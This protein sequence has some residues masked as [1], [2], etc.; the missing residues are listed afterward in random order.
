M[1]LANCAGLA[2]GTNLR[3]ALAEMCYFQDESG[4]LREII[5]A[6]AEE[7]A[8][9]IRFWP[10][11]GVY[12]DGRV[13]LYYLGIE[14]VDGY[15][16][17]NFRNLG[18]GLAVMNLETGECQRIRQSGEWRLW[19]LEAD[20]F[21]FG[22]QVIREGDDLLVFGSVRRDFQTQAILGRVAIDQIDEPEAYEYLQEDPDRWGPNIQTAGSLGECG[23]D[24][25]VSYNAYLSQYLM[26]Y[27]DSYTKTLIMRTADTIT[28]PYSE[29]QKIGRV[30]HRPSSE[31][32]Y[33]GFEHPKFAQDNG[34]RIIVS[35]CQ[36][37]FTQNN[38]LEIRFR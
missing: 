16:Q 34:Q 17:W 8:K 4:H 9:G 25:S 24:Y 22:V 13:Y 5:Q 10:A 32:A 35:Y 21:H 7:K 11:H 6:T 1:I 18:A 28:G 12:R 26:V 38:L 19:H 36:P 37:S 33:L 3:E 14:M 23:S 30:P 20:D 15:S 31:L 27:I 29:P 2:S